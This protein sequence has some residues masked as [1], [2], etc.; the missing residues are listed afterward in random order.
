MV[1]I[2]ATEIILD[3]GDA[4]LGFNIRGGVDIPHVKGD[5]GI[6]VTK[7]R[8]NGAAY[9]DGRLKE[10]DKILEINGVKLDH[11][12]HNEAVKCFVEAGTSVHLIVQH[13]AEE[14]IIRRERI[15]KAEESSEPTKTSFS[16]IPI[17]IAVSV[18][19][20]AGI[21]VYKKHGKR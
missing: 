16:W 7:I 14:A 10:G 5:V 17:I 18:I 19:L 2:P 21:V 9:K 8:E 3:R 6:F 4:G 15:Q 12:T 11:V 1:D 13:G 20:V